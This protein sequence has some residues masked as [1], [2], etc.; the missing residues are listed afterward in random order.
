MFSQNSNIWKDE[1]CANYVVERLVKQQPNENEVAYLQ[2]MIK[3][4]DY[5]GNHVLTQLLKDAFPHYNW[6]N[7]LASV[8]K[9][10][11]YTLKECIGKLFTGDNSVM[12]EE[13]KHPEMSHLE[14]DYFFPQYNLAFEYQVKSFK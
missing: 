14:L 8:G 3:H 7:S 13:Y 5:K 11:Q 12:V 2:K 9:K 4:M 6:S 10:A 1:T